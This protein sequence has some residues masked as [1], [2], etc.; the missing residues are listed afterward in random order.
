MGVKSAAFQDCAFDQ[1]LMSGT[2]V[3]EAWVEQFQIS[4]KEELRPGRLW[5]PR[6]CHSTTYLY[7][8]T[9]QNLMI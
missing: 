1:I 6:T 9:A 4:E 7:P 3:A 8:G 5:C 2:Y